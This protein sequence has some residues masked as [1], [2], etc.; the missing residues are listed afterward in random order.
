M[1]KAG[2]TITRAIQS[3]SWPVTSANLEYAAVWGS[4]GPVALDVPRSADGVATLRVSTL[5]EPAGRVDG[6]PARLVDNTGVAFQ[7]CIVLGKGFVLEPAEAAAWM[8]ADPANAEVLFP[9][10]NG[11]DL[12]S[13]PDASPSR[14]VI[15]FN[16]RAESA[17][18]EY[19][20]PYQRV[21]SEVL[22][23]RKKKAKAVRNAPWWL[24]LRPRPAMRKAI[25]GLGEVLVIALVSKTVMPMRVPTGQVFSHKLGVFAFDS[26]NDQALLSSSLHQVWAVKY[27]GRQVRLDDARRRQLLTV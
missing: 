27:G 20:L 19:R 10:L 25:A 18:R 3:R 22:P 4:R 24:F 6:A 1:D 11:E 13:R 17:A 21:S 5:L 16:D 12:N 7:G 14:W 8:S 23:D 9:Y 26:F 15:D 2:F